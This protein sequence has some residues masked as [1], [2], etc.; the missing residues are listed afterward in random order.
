MVERDS[1]CPTG[2]P[3]KTLYQEYPLLS[4]VIGLSKRTNAVVLVFLLPISKQLLLVDLSTR[5]IKQN[6]SRVLLMLG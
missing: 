2:A 4:I 6:S 3:K 1:S 5:R